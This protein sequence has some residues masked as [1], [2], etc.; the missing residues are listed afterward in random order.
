MRWNNDF[1]RENYG[2]DANVSAVATNSLRC[3]TSGYEHMDAH[4]MSRN[5]EVPREKETPVYILFFT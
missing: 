3:T 5:N 4:L 2:G 1:H